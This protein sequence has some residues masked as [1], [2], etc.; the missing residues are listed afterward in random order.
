MSLAI[1]G[2]LTAW[3][4]SLASRSPSTLEKT[5]KVT[6]NFTCSYSSIINIPIHPSTHPFIHTYIHLCVHPWIH[7]PIHPLTHSTIYTSIYVSIHIS[8]HTHIYVF[9]Q[10]PTY[11]IITFLNSI[12]VLSGSNPSHNTYSYVTLGKIF[13]PYMTPILLH[14]FVLS[15]V[16][17]FRP[18]ML[19][20][21]GALVTKWV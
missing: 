14:K 13:D 20:T 4:D 19:T 12:V 3:K 16:W 11:S 15:Q 18:L 5:S 2:S 8:I 7:L 1:C 6:L 9:I 21:Q 17:W 10:L